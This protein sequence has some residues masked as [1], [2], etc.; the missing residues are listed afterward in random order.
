MFETR[1]KILYESL[2]GRLHE[3][4]YIYIYKSIERFLIDFSSEKY[5]LRNLIL[6]L[7][8]DPSNILHLFIYLNTINYRS[9]RVFEQLVDKK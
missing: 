9:E 2:V 7:S 4:I 1:V 8:S 5:V 3:L 6:L